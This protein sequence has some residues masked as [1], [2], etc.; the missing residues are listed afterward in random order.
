[1]MVLKCFN[2]PFSPIPTRDSGKERL[3]GRRGMWTCLKIV[4][5]SNSNLRCQQSNPLANT[6]R[7]QQWQ[8]DLFGNH[9]SW[10]SNGSS[11]RRNCE[12]PPISLSPQAA[13][14]C[15][16]IMRS[17]LGVTFYE[18]TTSEDQQCYVRRTNT[19]ASSFSL[20]G[21][22]YILSKHCM[23]SHMSASAEY[24]TLVS[25]SAKYP[26]PVSASAKHH[27]T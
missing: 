27:M 8:S 13:R 11:S 15:R 5:W 21:H 9:H 7:N 19:R 20:W 14:S 17:S 6:N 4:L 24:P 16:N 2:L 3:I 22:I 23:F 1:M 10:F 25:A 26:S 12:A 18:V